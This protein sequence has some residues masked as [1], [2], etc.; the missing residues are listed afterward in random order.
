[1]SQLPSFRKLRH[2]RTPVLPLRAA[3][4]VL[5]SV[6]IVL[7]V[8]ITGGLSFYNGQRAVNEL[9]DRLLARTIRQ[10]ELEIDRYFQAPQNVNHTLQS[11][12]GLGTIDPDNS[13]A[14]A[15]LFAQQLRF[16]DNIETIQFATVA[17]DWRYFGVGYARDGS[18][19]TAE[20]REGT[21]ATDALVIKRADRET[22]EF[23]QY[24]Y[25]EDGSAGEELDRVPYDLQKR[26]WY[27]N[28]I[29]RDRPAWSRIYSTA[30]T[31]ELSIVRTDPVRDRQ[32]RKIGIIG[33]D[34]R[35]T[36][37]ERFLAQATAGENGK[38][39][40]VER[41]TRQPIASSDGRSMV[42]RD[43]DGAEV[44]LEIGDVPE[45]A[46]V[47]QQLESQAEMQVET[48]AAMAGDGAC[49]RQSRALTVSIEGAAYFV[50]V[51]SLSESL[52]LDWLL[53]S[54]VPKADF[55]ELIELQKR[56]TLAFCA[57]ALL[58]SLGA[59]VLIGRSI[60]R[61]IL[62]L[63]RVAPDLAGGQ[64]DPSQLD[65]IRP[66]LRIREIETLRDA[67]RAM[68]AQVSESFDRLESR[69]DRRTAELSQSQ[70][71]FASIFRQ[72][73]HPS[74]IV[75]RRTGRIVE[76]NARFF[77]LFGIADTGDAI[78]NTEEHFWVD[79]A[80]RQRA[81]EQIE[82]GEDIRDREAAF[83]TASGAIVTVLLSAT[84]IELG[85]DPCL[86]AT[87]TDISERLLLD[88]QLRQSQQFLDSIIEN[89]PVAVFVKDV[90]D[91]FRLTR[92][93]QQ[94]EAIA[95]RPRAELE[96]KTVAELY[97]P[98]QA[99][100]FR[101]HDRE[102]IE[103]GAL[104][105]FDAEP[106]TNACGHTMLLRTSKV[107][108]RDD[109]GEI[110]YI[111]GIS[112]DIT[113]LHRNHAELCAQREASPDGIL[114]FD[115]RDEISA[116]NQRFCEMWDIPAETFEGG[117]EAVL[118]AMRA[119]MKTPDEFTTTLEYHRE[120]R[121]LNSCNDIEVLVEGRGPLFFERYS[122]AVRDRADSGDDFGRI[123]FFR[124]ITDLKR[125]ERKLRDNEAYM[126]IILD[127]IP[128][129][130]F[131]K[132]TNLIFQG[133]NRHWAT[134]AGLQSP[135]EAFGK[136]DFDLLPPDLA[137]EFREADRA[138]IETNTPMLH[139][140]AV[141]FQP[142]EDGRKIWLDISKLPIH[143]RDG[144]AIG[145]LG[146]LDDITIRREAQ[147]ALRKEQAR[148]EK[149]LLNILPK[150]IADS[151]KIE[152]RSIAKSFQ[153]ASILFADI[154]GF[155]PLSAELEPIELVNLLNE[156]FTEFDRLAAYHGL[157]KI[158]TI[159]DAYMVAGGLPME[160]A[161]HIDAIAAMALDMQ[162]ETAKLRD[163]LDRDFAIR[164]GVHIGPVVAGVIG[165]S[166]F[167]YDLWGD[168]VNVASRM[169]SSGQPGRVQITEATY[170][171]IQNHY[172][173]ELRGTIDVKG[174]GKMRT[175]WLNSMKGLFYYRSE[176]DRQHA[177][178]RLEALR[179]EVSSEISPDLS[180]ETGPEV[181]PKTSPDES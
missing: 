9:V 31:E 111:L 147:E 68:Y 1:M 117:T 154:V 24:R 173:C 86:M 99:E 72:S 137:R 176:G 103:R 14:L 5:F 158:K 96:G 180:P 89:L 39:Y 116:H 76:A 148:S 98:E 75:D 141:K 56:Q 46:R 36:T 41:D 143:D 95:G 120:F 4:L 160:N 15:R 55:L 146:V 19:A 58:V 164:V 78:G 11:A 90:R 179:A 174:K 74:A 21:R 93:N 138:I 104:V 12:I 30:S 67:F 73:P 102:T 26:E 10:L 128:Q 115:E 59:V 178:R 156:I 13:D 100:R 49:V 57:I 37:I 66:R 29:A 133:C 106:L 69:V 25:R 135:S 181:S 64:L 77:E 27:A 61:P 33:T 65:R 34:L 20:D 32:G 70:E 109:R 60:G 126:R 85:D 17:E 161:Y 134:A 140:E 87:A 175:Y 131:W 79:P 83:R 63:S 3:T 105:E 80:Q 62:L 130:V 172:N 23:V 16:F 22:G 166:K 47:W 122:N 165:T 167:I 162:K 48:S 119:R 110:A 81:I 51:V 142:G 101:A 177:D 35:L 53:V 40:L 2:W 163:R 84:P 159:G 92:L 44:R 123:W 118:D 82:R 88:R 6:P 97:L 129:Q 42:R 145:I 8:G 43:A 50:C 113:D 28:A 169:E 91:D 108:I 136:S 139:V 107:P 45:L 168:T 132:D 52:G 153:C 38:A 155:T 54:F 18:P 152:Q 144:N 171:T 114:V 127:N 157:E 124:D 151:L 71:R 121:H 150:S 94:Y 7:A 149:L 170:R 125:N 112:E